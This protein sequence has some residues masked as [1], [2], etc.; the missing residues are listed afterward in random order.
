MVRVLSVVCGI[1]GMGQAA[2]SSRSERP[3]WRRKT[4]SRLGLW[5]VIEV[6][7]SP[8]PSSI[9]SRLRDGEL[10]TVHVESDEPVRV[11]RRLADER[12][13]VHQPEDQGP[14]AVHADRHDVAG[15]GLLELV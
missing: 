13:V 9:R 1:G 7:A 14:G 2:G 12:H 5:S 15:D 10:A 6:G 8:A 3:V 4:S 11:V